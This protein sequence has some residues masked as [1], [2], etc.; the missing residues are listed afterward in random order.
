M[1][2]ISQAGPVYDEAHQR[3]VYLSFL[4]FSV[5]WAAVTVT[6]ALVEGSLSDFEVLQ[7]TLS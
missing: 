2:A 4:T 3:R 7:E 1:R 5:Q 6:V